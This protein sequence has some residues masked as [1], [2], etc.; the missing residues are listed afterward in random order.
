MDIK[1]SL[2][3]CDFYLVKLGWNGQTLILVGF[4]FSQAAG[5]GKQ[6]SPSHLIS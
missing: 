6:K 3:N 2:L 1:A 5:N 4:V